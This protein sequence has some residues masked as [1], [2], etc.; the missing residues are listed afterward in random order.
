MASATGVAD[1]AQETATLPPAARASVAFPEAAA[2]V[3]TF[4]LGSTG[5]DEGW[6]KVTAS[7]VCGT[8]VELFANGV[9]APTVLGHHVVAVVAAVGPDA[10]ARRGLTIGDRLVLEEYLPC[11][12]CPTC[13]TGPYR[14]CPA[15]DIW[16]GG[17]RIGTLPVTESP[18]L[19]GGN[20][21]FLFLGAS[22]VTHR[23]PDAVDDELAAWVLPYANALDWVSDAAVRSGETVIVLG[24]GYHGVAVV[25][26][27]L[28]AGASRVIVSGLSCDAERLA[29]CETLGASPVVADDPAVT[30]RQVHELTG[31]R[32]V[33]AVLDTVG[34][35]AGVLGPA[36]N[37]LGHGGR[38]VLTHPKKPADAT[39]DTARL[40]RNNL[41]ISGVRG[42]SPEAINTAISSLAHGGS[43]LEK[44]PSV[45]I[46]LDETGEMLARLA[47][48]TGPKSP[49]IVVRP[50]R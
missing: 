9:P 16:Q 1:T 30:T 20:A 42:R 18:G 49:H 31:G 22:T 46:G 34:A 47:A 33:D 29:I 11:G 24:P 35:D 45:E 48:G 26:A 37:L 4:E 7:G 2:E 19:T 36:L 15:T 23:L 12:D 14:L 6:L 5:V 17:R 21:E 13:A 25:A 27:A 50:G 8:D 43:G 32:P 41:R 10:A 28:R 3:R 44:V 40:I 38:L 39:F